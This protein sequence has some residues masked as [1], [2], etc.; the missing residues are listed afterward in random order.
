MLGVRT[1]DSISSTDE[2]SSPP[3]RRRFWKRHRHIARHSVGAA[4]RRCPIP[5][6]TRTGSK[7]RPACSMAIPGSA[8]ANTYSLSCT[9]H[10]TRLPTRSHSSTRHGFWHWRIPDDGQAPLFRYGL[11]LPAAG[12]RHAPHGAMRH[13][14]VLSRR[15]GLSI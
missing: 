14:G 1:S 13:D 4:A 10:G 2:T 5:T 11:L 12:P 9:R 7:S 3:T 15:C 8:P 6:P